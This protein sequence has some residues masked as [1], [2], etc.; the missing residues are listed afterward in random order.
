M[1]IRNWRLYVCMCACLYILSTLCI[2]TISHPFYTQPLPISASISRPGG[3]LPF[4][5]KQWIPRS[6]WGR[7]AAPSLKC[8]FV[9]VPA[10]PTQRI[11]PS[12]HSLSVRTPQS[13]SSSLVQWP[14][15][16]RMI[17]HVGD[18]IILGHFRFQS[19]NLHS[20]S[21]YVSL[22]RI[23]PAHMLTCPDRQTDRQTGGQTDSQLASA[24]LL[25]GIG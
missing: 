20:Q 18:G 11:F 13:S 3:P 16:L 21:K 24:S 22:R 19:N 4:P 15:R 17:G 25:A 7:A 12:S 1:K 23:F 10:E 5:G 8:H 14:S 2:P 6:E 9:S